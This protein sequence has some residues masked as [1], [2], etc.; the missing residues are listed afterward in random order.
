MS[1]FTLAVLAIGCT[2]VATLPE[3]DGP[4]EEPDPY[5]V[6]D[7]ERDIDGDGVLELIIASPAADT[8]SLI[9]P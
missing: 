6:P 9:T 5:D 3:V 8:V 7:E 4:A 2:N 1:I